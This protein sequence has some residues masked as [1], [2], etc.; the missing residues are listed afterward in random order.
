MSRRPTNMVRND[1]GRKSIVELAKH[2][3]KQHTKHAPEQSKY[4]RTAE[5]ALP[6]R[7]FGGELAA[8]SPPSPCPHRHL[9]RQRTASEHGDPPHSRTSWTAKRVPNPFAFIGQAMHQRKLGGLGQHTPTT[10]SHRGS[11]IWG[12]TCSEA[13]CSVGDRGPARAEP[14]QRKSPPNP[15]RR[16]GEAPATQKCP[17]LVSDVLLS[18]GLAPQY[19]RRS[20]A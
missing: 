14:P 13:L 19:H 10:Y 16:R 17:L 11:E 9:K 5:S 6:P 18:H 2:S 3:M 20:G 1:C 12:S 4:W 8:R 15:R 7:V